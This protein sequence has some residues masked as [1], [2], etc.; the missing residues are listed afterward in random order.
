M[1][2]DLKGGQAPGRWSGQGAVYL[3]PLARRRFGEDV[4]L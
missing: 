2:L 4:K 1:D 3:K